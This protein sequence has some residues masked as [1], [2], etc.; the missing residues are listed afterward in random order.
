MPVKVTKSAENDSSVSTE[1]EYSDQED[2]EI[3]MGSKTSGQTKENNLGHFMHEDGIDQNAAAIYNCDNL[4]DLNFNASTRNSS[5]RLMQN[6]ESNR[7]LSNVK[8][9]LSNK[10]VQQH[11]ISKSKTNLE[12]T[13]LPRRIRCLKE[14][15]E[16]TTQQ[17]HNLTASCGS[18]LHL[19]TR[20]PSQG[21]LEGLTSTSAATFSSNIQATSSDD[22]TCQHFVTKTNRASLER[23]VA[24]TSVDKPNTKTTDE[25]AVKDLEADETVLSAMVQ[26]KK[27]GQVSKSTDG[28]LMMAVCTLPTFTKPSQSSRNQLE[29]ATEKGPSSSTQM[30][31]GTC[32]EGHRSDD[33]EWSEQE[34]G[35]FLLGL[36]TYGD[37]Y[38]KVAS[39]IKTR[40]YDQVCKHAQYHFEKVD[41][42]SKICEIL[43][44]ANR[45][46][47]KTTTKPN[48]VPKR[49][50][51]VQ[52]Y[53]WTNE[54][55]RLLQKG[56][57]KYGR[58]L[59]KIAQLIPSRTVEQIEAYVKRL[60]HIEKRDKPQQEVK[61]EE[62]IGNT[63]DRR[64]VKRQLTTETEYQRMREDLLKYEER[65]RLESEQKKTTSMINKKIAKVDKNG[66]R[67]VQPPRLSS[68]EVVR[69]RED[70]LKY[71]ER[72]RRENCVSGLPVLDKVSNGLALIGDGLA[73]P[74]LKVGRVQTAII[75]LPSVD[76]ETWPFFFC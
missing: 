3:Q 10:L 75:S 40:S 22:P 41:R 16:T 28:R 73:A 57:E 60:L 30:A 76:F 38:D 58:N 7:K 5:R 49:T 31:L 11:Q 48:D 71:E 25:R 2:Y 21:G 17:K 32:M 35:L 56:L 4:P 67:V 23:S 12:E 70:L 50:I 19:P 68:A 9:L 6:K 61:H 13:N 66:K 27:N 34:L 42:I 26:Q 1:T 18:T 20:R 24:S 55:D 8:G 54:E 74:D 59:T 14:N 15:D 43:E 44:D 36:K 51:Q 63:D 37:D 52:H 39:L 64:G 33:D 65:K 46:R 47:S 45:R 69:M 62:S 53:E 29:T 72:K